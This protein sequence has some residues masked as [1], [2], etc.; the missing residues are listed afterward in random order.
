LAESRLN[1]VS[2]I[3]DGVALV[4]F[5]PLYMSIKVLSRG[6]PLS[7]LARS[8]AAFALKILENQA[9]FLPVIKQRACHLSVCKD[10][11]E[12]INMMILASKSVNDPYLTPL[13]SV[14]G[15]AS[16]MVADYIASQGATKI[17]VD[18]GGDIAIRVREGEN[19]RVGLRLNLK[20]PDFNYTLLVDKDCGL[21]TSGFGGRSFTLGVADG[22][23]VLAGKASTA[24]AFATFLANKTTVNSSEIKRV[25]AESIYPE[26]DIAGSKITHSIGILNDN[27]IAMAINKG[28]EEAAKLMEK[29]LINGA[30]FSVK[31]HVDYVGCFKTAVRVENNN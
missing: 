26:T 22:V 27:E 1:E 14:A 12:V 24:D 4:D 11:P 15:A 8:G 7:G 13:A 9:K 30:I 28:K 18:N 16:D 17:V 20:R 5:G 23:T 2:L 31:D 25:W 10:Y 29:K 6:I 19:V 3:R 21:C